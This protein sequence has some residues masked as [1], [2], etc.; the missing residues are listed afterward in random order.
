MIDPGCR[1][2]NQD[3]PLGSCIEQ[4]PLK[5]FFREFYGHFCIGNCGEN[6]DE[7]RQSPSVETSMNS[8]GLTFF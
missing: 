6:F 8:D 2:G 5:P 4:N 7:Y 1:D 3:L